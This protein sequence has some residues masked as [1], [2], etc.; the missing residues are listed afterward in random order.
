MR[1]EQEALGL[2]KTE[3]S[4]HAQIYRKLLRNE[5]NEN[6]RKGGTESVLD[7]GKWRKSEVFSS[8]SKHSRYSFPH[9]VVATPGAG[10]RSKAQV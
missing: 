10:A 8:F 1:L 5:E 7:R 3:V 2:T 4:I 6:Q 9:V